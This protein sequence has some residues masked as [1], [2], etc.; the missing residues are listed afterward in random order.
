MQP[1]K[2]SW[3]RIPSAHFVRLWT[4]WNILVDYPLIQLKTAAK[5][6]ELI[7]RLFDWCFTTLST[8]EFYF[9]ATSIENCQKMSDQN[10]ALWRVL[11][12]R[13]W[14]EIAL[15]NAF[16]VAAVVALMNH[17]G[18]WVFYAFQ[19]VLFYFEWD[20]QT[21]TISID[22]NATQCSTIWRLL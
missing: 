3:K 4:A 21:M 10:V 18:S 12:L 17:D 22:L 5:M 6:V 9:H 14:E 7:S 13:A 8:I 1:A 19:I 15:Q 11:T 16:A 20:H 2:N